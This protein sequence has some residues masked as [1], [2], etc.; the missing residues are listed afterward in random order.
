MNKSSI[1]RGLF[2]AYTYKTITGESKKSKNNYNSESIEY[3]SD[4][5]QR[6]EWNYSYLDKKT[7]IINTRIKTFK[8]DGTFYYPEIKVKKG[9]VIIGK[10]I[11]ESNKNGEEVKKDYSIVIKTGEEGIV[12]HVI[13]S[14]TPG[15]YTLVKVVI[16]TERIPEVGDKFAARSAQ[17]G[18]LGHILSQEDMPFTEEGI[19]PDIIINTHSLPSQSGSRE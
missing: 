5:I 10:V 17:K 11:T 19:V 18:L 13:T 2:V 8:S 1:D 7:G 12:D 15:G 16:R 6:K 9:D 4:E 3:P 14:K